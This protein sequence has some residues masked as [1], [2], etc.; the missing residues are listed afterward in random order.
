MVQL[1]QVL[2]SVRVLVG[3][4]RLIMNLIRESNRRLGSAIGVKLSVGSD[5]SGASWFFC[6]R[7]QL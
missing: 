7:G 5:V 6:R 3:H 2:A 1:S 4:V